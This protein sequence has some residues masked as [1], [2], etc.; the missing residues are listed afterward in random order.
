LIGPGTVNFDFS[1]FKNFNFAEERRLQFR[2]EFFNIFN[3]ANFDLP[4]RLADTPQFGRIF[5]ASD[6]RRVQF[7]LKYIF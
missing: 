5:S 1:L 7:A 4:N 6:G 2:S 3:H